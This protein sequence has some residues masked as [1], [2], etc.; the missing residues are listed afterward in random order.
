M[1]SIPFIPPAIILTQDHPLVHPVSIRCL[2]CAGTAGLGSP[3]G[4]QEPCSLPFLLSPPPHH[5]RAAFYAWI[6][7]E[8]VLAL[9]CL[10]DKVQL[11]GLV[12]GSPAPLACSP[13]RG[14]SH[15]PP[16]PCSLAFLNALLFQKHATQLHDSMP[17]DTLFP[18]T[19]II[20]GFVPVLLVLQD[21]ATMSPLESL[22]LLA[23]QGQGGSFPRVPTVHV[24]PQCL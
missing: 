19:G 16:T 1:Q 12:H 6:F 18:L 21:R 3:P 24:S 10:Q 5:R 9:P 4:A 13:S 22:S 11:I 8:N 15:C 7:S 20:T 14:S 23:G 17:Q 2:W